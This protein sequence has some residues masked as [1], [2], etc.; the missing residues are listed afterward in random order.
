[1]TSYDPNIISGV[2]TVQITMQMWDYVGHIIQKIRGNCKGME[3]LN[4]DFEIED[5]FPENDCQLEYHEDGDFFSCILKNEN[6]DTL[7]CENDA[8][9]MN[10]MIVAVEILSF[11]RVMD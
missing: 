9:E 3:I 7:E 2:H 4:F 8:Q 11:E 1:M 10:D 5:E 6:G